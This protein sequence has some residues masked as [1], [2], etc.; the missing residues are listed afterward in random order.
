MNSVQRIAKNTFF[1]TFMNII[2][3]LL[4]VIFNVVIAR[5]FGDVDFGKYTFSISFAALFAIVINWGLNQLSIR[6]I[7]R[8]KSNA[9]SHLVNALLI[10][11]CLSIIYLSIICVTTNL[12]GY[13]NDTK[14][15]VYI[16]ALYTILLSFGDS[17]KAIFH[18]FEKMQY[19]SVLKIIEK[20]LIVV[21]G[22]LLLYLGFDLEKIIMVY[23][24]AGSLSLILGHVIT[25]KKFINLKVDIDFDLCK[26]LIVA[27]IPIGF[28][29]MFLAINNKV[30]IVMLSIIKNNSTVGWYGAANTLILALY[31]IPTS[32]VNSIFPF[33]SKIDS[34]SNNSLK[35]AYEIS[36]KY[37]L[38]I[39]VP[40]VF[41]TIGLA[42]KI[43]LLTYGIQYVNSILALQI[44]IVSII[45]IF[46]HN[47]IGTLI[48]AI[49]KERKAVLMWAV[50]AL[51]NVVLNVFLIPNYGHIGAAITTVISETILCAQFFY[52]ISN[53][54][55]R[56]SLH[57][58]FIKPMLGSTIMIIFLYSNPNLNLIFSII[59]SVIIYFLTLIFLKTFTNYDRS[60]FKKVFAKSKKPKLISNILLS[61]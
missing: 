15:L 3:L 25:I 45:P 23:L 20:L 56:I 10:K 11:F 38:I 57:K 34:N 6:E 54:F 18:A 14:N 60:L 58:F 33:F 2:V 4:G 13:S 48:L 22:L 19:S 55:H 46:I 35:T 8:E 50:C 12:I 16:F 9:N 61:K 29:A 49:N 37:L 52:F 21:L 17:Y 32:F 53:N 27:A 42:S 1:L 30:D 5:Y 31:F 51:T 26:K 41:G 28:F 59:I 39:A 47:L 7:A 44:L 24:F 40:I 36:L 43:I